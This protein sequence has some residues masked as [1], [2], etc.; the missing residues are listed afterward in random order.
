MAPQQ[1]SGWS[2]SLARAGQIAAAAQPA[3]LCT[4]RHWDFVGI[5]GVL[6][7]VLQALADRT[8]RDPEDVLLE[9]L[10]EHCEQGAGHVRT[11]AVALVGEQLAH[12]V[13]T[14]PEAGVPAAGDSPVATWLW[15]TRLW[16]PPVP[17]DVDGLP[18]LRARRHDGMIRGIARG[19]PGAAVDLLPG[20]AADA[21]AA[22][23]RAA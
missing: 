7:V 11:L 15:L 22:T 16:P 9:E 23:L 4:D 12:S 14:D 2:R 17:D 10:L 8:G 18:P 1:T 5:R 19:H 13:D 6:A 3:G 21:V 20:W